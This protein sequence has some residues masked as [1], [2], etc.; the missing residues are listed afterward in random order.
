MLN[1]HWN[2]VGS[3]GCN[4][5]N[6]L[7]MFQFAFMEGQKKCLAHMHV[8]SNLNIGWYT[9]THAWHVFMHIL[10]MLECVRHVGAHV[11]IAHMQLQCMTKI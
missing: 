4:N 11:H 2:W 8:I 1:S 6:H 10:H 3:H 7:S 9:C 5:E